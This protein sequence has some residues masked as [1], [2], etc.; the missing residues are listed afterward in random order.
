MAGMPP[1]GDGAGQCWS[2]LVRHPNREPV[3]REVLPPQN[4][5]ELRVALEVLEDQHLQIRDELGQYFSVDHIGQIFDGA[6]LRVT[7]PRR[8]IFVALDGSSVSKQI[9][10][11]PGTG[12]DQIESAIVKACGLQ[13]G[14]P[15][16]LMDGDSAVVISPTIPNDSF[17]T[18]V[19][20]G[21]QMQMSQTTQS[22]GG[23]KPIDRGLAPESPRQR[24]PALGPSSPTTG[25]P[26]SSRGPQRDAAAS[27]AN[28]T[29]RSAGGSCTAAGAAA[30]AR[31]GT[32][33]GS[34]AQGRPAARRGEGNPVP[35][36]PS[37]GS[38]PARQ[39]SPGADMSAQPAGMTSAPEEHCVHILAGHNGS[40]LSLCSVGDVL[41]TGS[42]DCN[43]MIWDLNNLQ[44]I[45]TL[46]GHRGFVKC[47]AATL[48]RKILCSGS[49][50]KTIKIWS[51]ES[52]SSKKTLFGHTSEVN[53]L[54][55]LDGSDVLISG[56][57]DRSIRIWDLSSLALL[58]SLDQAHL[59]GIFTV[60]QLEPG[61][62]ISASRDRTMKVWL[63]STWQAGRTLSPPHYD[64]V[65]DLA[66]AP[67]KGCFFSA[68][69]DRSIRRW[70]VKS[71]ESDL[72]LAH[73]QGDWLAALAL[74]PSENVLFSGGKDSIIKVWD[75]DLHC[76]DLLQGHRGGIS[77]LMTLDSHLFSASHDRTVR[78]WK[79][80][81]FDR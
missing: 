58:A 31:S 35:R 33:V 59:S 27:V 45:G 54:T 41:F 24:G 44:Y 51:L 4:L 46:P 20:L 69:R 55:I 48:A 5:L 40:V 14:T 71:L 72:Q 23:T 62:F 16:E 2:L 76:M 34:A 56:G 22:N 30:R 47:M 21:G 38:S 32:P 60:K 74:L 10:W 53:A 13:L 65:S 37:R 78:V 1:N 79:V 18:V 75:T 43:I 3:L 80:D 49:Q 57:E 68:S 64:G 11:Y 8:R 66:V 50:D 29:A 26:V 61:M 36:P 70:S 28:G 7:V 19:P 67:K 77:S 63:A 9:V 25:R 73:A 12:T 52:F 39:P 81:H 15:V 42:Q 17:L 6:S